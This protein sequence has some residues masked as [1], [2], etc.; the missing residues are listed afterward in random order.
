MGSG[1]LAT[2]R[3]STRE[4]FKSSFAAPTRAQELAWPAIAS[5][6]STLVLA[7]TGS[8]K[9]LAAFLS[10]ID[11]LLHAEPAGCRVVYISPL[12]ALAV[13]VERNLRG[14]LVGIRHTAERLGTPLREPSVAIRTGDTPA[15]DRARFV[16]T[17]A[18]IF[19][20]TPESL[21]LVLSSSARESLRNVRTVIVDEIHAM[22]ATKRGAHLALSLER[23][24]E[25]AGRPLQRIGLSATQR[26]LDEVARFLVGFNA[27]GPRPVKIVDAGHTKQLDLRV[28][29]PVDDMSK[30]GTETLEIR[31]GPASRADARSSIW[32]AIHPR[33]LEL[34]R[35]HRSTLIFVN[36]R[37]LA[38]RIAS[39]VNELAGEEL[40]HSH[41]GSIAREQRIRIEDDLK[42]GK[43]RALVATPS[44]AA[45]SASAA[46]ATR[47]TRRARA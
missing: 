37:R 17:P 19:I 28:E 5:G 32:P 12:K 34:I 33:L 25:L 42:A 44:R 15:K 47:S 7:P 26:P 1:A 8:G 9:T 20:T 10:A 29:V 22:V 31:S 16:K 21:Y 3:E 24:E 41:H 40:V 14:P 30:L 38:E 36:S 11:Q 2:F 43:R 45:C 35:E 46:P 18:D 13:D 27:D 39:A 23:L 4:W 6:E